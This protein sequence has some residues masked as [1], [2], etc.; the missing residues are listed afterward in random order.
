MKNMIMAAAA[1][2]MFAAAADEKPAEL[3]ER[4]DAGGNWRIEIGGFGRGRAKAKVDGMGSKRFETYGADL[5][6]QYRVWNNEDFNVWA[7]I[8]GTFCPRQ[9]ASGGFGGRSSQSEHQVSD[10]GYTTYDFNYTSEER[11]KAEVGYG[12]FRMMLVPEWNVWDRL[13]L[14]ARLGVAFDWINARYSGRSAWVWN[15]AFSYNIPGMPPA[16]STDSDSGRSSYSETHTQFAAQ[17]ILGLQA[18]YMFTDNLGL[19]ANFDWRMGDDAEFGAGNGRELKVDMD[20]WYWGA[21]V[22]FAF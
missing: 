3:V 13:F 14:G 6:L 10:D 22:V 15:S 5:D 17:A 9:K 12:E 19:Y 2:A 7:G 8:G 1:C 4:E 20:G 16:T 21:G 18:T 11:G